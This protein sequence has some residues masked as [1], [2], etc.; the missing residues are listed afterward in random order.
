MTSDPRT[1]SLT[2]MSTAFPAAS[3]CT[4][5]HLAYPVSKTSTAS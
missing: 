5:L 1:K 2:L 3:T 4:H